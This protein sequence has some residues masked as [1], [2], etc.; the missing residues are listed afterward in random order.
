MVR[1]N[2]H[3]LEL[4]VGA[5]LLIDLQRVWAPSLITIFGQ[6]A[7]TP[8]ELMGLFALAV[9]AA[10]GLLLAAVR[11]GAPERRS[12][13]AAWCLTGALLLRMLVQFVGGGGAQLWAATAGMVLVLTWLCLAMRH[14]SPDLL[15]GVLAGLALA[16]CTHA[17]FGTWGAAWRSDAWGWG[18]LG[19][20]TAAVGWVF[21]TAKQ[22]PAEPGPASRLLGVTLMPALLVAGICVANVGRAMA[23]SGSLGAALVSAATVGAAGL[24][25]MRPRLPIWVIALDA[26]LLVGATWVVL[27]ESMGS[28]SS[29]AAALGMLALAGVL[30]AVVGA[31][32]K[33]ATGAAA[34]D[35]AAGSTESLPRFR[36][37]PLAA[38]WA[39][40][41]GWVV[42]FF[43]Y[44]A[45]YDLGY[46]ADWLIVA[47]AGVL[48]LAAV[49]AAWRG[50]DE[51]PVAH[52]APRLRSVLVWPVA[53]AVAFGLTWVGP[54][55]TVRPVEHPSV[56]RAPGL[57]VMA[58]NLRM[59]YG[60]DGRFRVREVAELIA[61]EAPDVVLL[62]EIDR[63]WLLNGGQDQLEILA[64]LLDMEAHF[65]P[66]ADPVWGDAI[67]TRLPVSRV[68]TRRLPDF[69]APTGAQIMAATVTKDGVE[70]DVVST[71]LQPAG[72]GPDGGRLRQAE[73]IADFVRD[74]K[75]QRP[76]VLGG[77]FNVVPGSE[78]FRVITDAGVDDALV[79]SRPLFT[80]PADGPEEQID[81]LF[82]SRGSWINAAWA[83]STQLSDHY[84][85]LITVAPPTLA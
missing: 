46:R 72:H 53:A 70:Y 80:S 50:R 16:T 32:Q 68:E 49:A 79:D 67:L 34:A 31:S 9:A 81:H 48:G 23:D 62:S 44:Y 15:A 84:P 28:G 57:T 73:R 13:W 69:G 20:Q 36:S 64:R 54:S 61:G 82:V 41:I 65:G 33:A 71:H 74:R 77:D 42:L 55:V 26:A 59:G 78:S 7:S 14:R 1:A 21:V 17:F 2:R 10:P 37:D 75:S 76:L 4:A 29:V 30:L 22:T 6:A 35:E 25:L 60:I 56:D 63:G 19:V 39:G 40:G 43:A 11:R 24:A 66:A 85:V 58:W 38:M 18:L 27:T 5:W 52:G 8:A 47:L 45:G 3:I 12:A 51:G 83:V